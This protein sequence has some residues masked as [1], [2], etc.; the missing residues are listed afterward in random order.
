MNDLWRKRLPPLCGAVG[1][2]LLAGAAWVCAGL[3]LGGGGDRLFVML[4]LFAMAA[5]AA[6]LIWF[7][8]RRPDWVLLALLPVGAAMLIRALCL[9][10]TSLDYKDFLSQWYGYFKTNGGFG[11]VKGSVGDYN[12]PYLY[13]MA[14]ISY[15]DVPDLYLIKLFSILWDVLL[16][17]GCLRLTRP[18]T[19]GRVGSVAPLI[20]FGAALLLPTVV[21][22]GAYWGQCDVI[23]GA[24]AIHAAA[25]TLDG[26]HKA[27]IALMGAAFSFKLQAIFVLPLWGV[28]WLAKKVKFGELWVFPLAYFGTIVPAL[29]LG[30]PLG[31]ILG[32]YLNQL[33]EYPRLVLNAPSV[34]QFIPYGTHLNEALVS[35]LGIAAAGALVLALMGLGVWLGNR[36]DRQLVMTVAVVLCVGIPFFLPHMHERY[37][38]LADVFTLCWACA[39]VRRVPAAVLAEGASLTSYLVYLRLKYNCVL[40]LGGRTF[41]MP[42]EALAMLAALVFAVWVLVWQVRERKNREGLA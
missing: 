4:A 39:N 33:G 25:L 24:L 35:K 17:W 13:F 30:K 12:V 19:G 32:V 36:L 8:S 15:S 16:A 10:H 34:Y 22:N 14:A 41:V 26:K 20:A 27:A 38:F 11:A 18:L 3:T 21:L 40:T 28:L 2:A 5:L 1:G 29:L 31:D 6:A 37:F 9:D 42:L 23:Y 7:E